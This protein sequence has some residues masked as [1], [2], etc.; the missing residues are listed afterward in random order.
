MLPP[1]WGSHR[2]E[3]IFLSTDTH[4][5]QLGKPAAPLF[6]NVPL[7]S[8]Q[9]PRS[10]S[11]LHRPFTSPATPGFRPW[12][13]EGGP[14]CLPTPPPFQPGAQVSNNR[15]GA[16]QQRWNPFG[17]A[18]GPSS[19]AGRALGEGCGPWQ[20]RCVAQGSGGCQGGGGEPCRA[21]HECGPLSPT[22]GASG[23][24]WGQEALEAEPVERGWRQGSVR[25][26]VHH[27]HH[28]VRD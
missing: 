27:G 8:A 22:G 14:T 24:V 4:I 10:G 19:Q 5:P 23:P 25:R 16:T 13:G 18:W 1:P 7:L 20:T 26:Q 9:G 3:Q 15:T 21:R 6:R 12:V 17:G 11:L 28:P 2:Q